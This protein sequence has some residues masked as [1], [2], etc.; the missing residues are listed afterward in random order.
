MPIE[1]SGN[2]IISGERR[3]FNIASNIV[4]Y[5][6]IGELPDTKYFLK[7]ET[8]GPDEEFLFNGVLFLQDGDKSGKIIDNFPKGPIP[9]GW[10]KEPLVD[11]E[12]YKLTD[13]NT[14]A[15][16]FGYR[17]IEQICYVITNVY[18]ENGIVI[19]EAN[20]NNLLIHKGPALIGRNGFRF[21]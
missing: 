9:K 19:A 3:M 2:I 6:E 1:M 20:G 10:T 4:P 15:I 7:G 12:G 14:G 13:N 21:R 11:A 8:V 5:F 18:N 17:V 16:I